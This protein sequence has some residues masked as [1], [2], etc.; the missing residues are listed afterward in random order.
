MS[1]V[2]TGNV[3]DDLNGALAAQIAKLQ[4][5]DPRDKESM[6]ACVDQSKA[7]AA[8]A[9]NVNRNTWNAIECVRLHSELDHAS[10]KIMY[11]APK[12]LSGPSDA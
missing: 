9:E 7:V 3:F 2:A 10:G 4:S 6:A 1:A 8:L 5:I 12:L 11:R